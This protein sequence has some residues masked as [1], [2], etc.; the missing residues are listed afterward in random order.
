[1]NFSRLDNVDSVFGLLVLL[2]IL[3]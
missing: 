1:M 3:I 2:G